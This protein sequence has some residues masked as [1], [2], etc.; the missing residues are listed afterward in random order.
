MKDT[1]GSPSP[2]AP[3]SGGNG[4]DDPW[5]WLG[6]GEL[7]LTN[8][9]GLSP[10]EAVQVAFIERLAETGASGFGLGLGMSGP[11]LG[12]QVWQRADELCLPLVTVPYSM[13]FTAVVRAVADANDREESRQLGRVA[14]LY[15]LLRASVL[16]GRS[17]PE[18][19]RKLGREL[20][21]RL[22][23][24]DPETG[25]SLFGDGQRP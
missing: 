17:G 7:L 4:D 12:R 13:P 14:R 8:G 5:K 20:D 18:L 24:V 16:A 23:L 25:L 15:E 21:V 19:F 3:V 9:A 10:N 1:L 6:S 2:G 22:Y 11:P